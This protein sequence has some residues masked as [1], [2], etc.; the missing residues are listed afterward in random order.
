MVDKLSPIR[1]TDEDA[2]RLARVLLRGARFGAL[3]V[4]EPEIGHPFASRVLLATDVDGTPVMLGSRLSTHTRALFNDPRCSLLVGEPGK[5]D[6]LA[7][8]RLT[9][10]AEAESIAAGSES[11]ERLRRRFLHRH[12]KSKLYVDFPDFSFFRLNPV[13]ASLNGGFGKAYILDKKDLVIDSA[14]NEYIGLEEYKIIAAINALGDGV[15]DLL[16]NKLFTEKS[17]GWRI[18]GLDMAG[19]ELV[20]KET[21]RRVE[22]DE[23]PNDVNA[24]IDVYAKILK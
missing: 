21:L 11:R 6:P 19:L 1:P 18:S 20:K 14:L 15:A 5:G 2:R 3:A 7:W 23:I 24:L 22:L 17:G 8:P 13:T 9:V 10:L 4:L 12:T 16:A